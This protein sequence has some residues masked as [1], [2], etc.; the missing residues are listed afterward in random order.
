[1]KLRN[2][3]LYV[4]KMVLHI[5]APGDHYYMAEAVERELARLFAGGI[6]LI[7]WLMAM[8]SVIWTVGHSKNLRIPD[9][10]RSAHRWRR[11]CIED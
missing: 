3:E 8:S 10:K 9:R 4:D 6:C 2:I 7:R 5:S 1:M 11:L